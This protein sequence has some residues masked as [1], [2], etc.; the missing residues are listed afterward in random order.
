MKNGERRWVELCAQAGAAKDPEE[1]ERILQELADLLVEMERYM[2]PQPPKKSH[3][4]TAI[5]LRKW[6]TEMPNHDEHIL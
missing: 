2:K 3:E 1:R 5:R 4:I 6:D